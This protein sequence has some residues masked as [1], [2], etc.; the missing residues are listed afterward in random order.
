MLK[1]TKPWLSREVTGDCHLSDPSE[2]NRGL[3]E[4]FKIAPHS[5]KPGISL[6][7]PSHLSVTLPLQSGTAV[8]SVAPFWSHC[9]PHVRPYTMVFPAPP[10]GRAP[11]RGPCLLFALCDPICVPTDLFQTLITCFFSVYRLAVAVSP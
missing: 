7:P 4:G 11:C 8:E 1:T 2:A 5:Q 3:A 6:H 10:S 9:G